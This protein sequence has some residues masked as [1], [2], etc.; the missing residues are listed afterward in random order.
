MI[1]LVD[2]L[3]KDPDKKRVEIH[4]L[5]DVKDALVK[6]AKADNRSLLN[7]IETLLT[8]HVEEKKKGTA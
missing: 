5:P 2:Q 4:L 6:L 1:Y 3:A 7:Y 8:R